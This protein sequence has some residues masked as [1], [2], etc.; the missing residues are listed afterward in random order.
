MATNVTLNG[1]TYSI[2]AVGDS[3]WGPSLSSFLIAVPTG[4]L[5]KAGG[6]FALTAGVD[7]GASFGL[8]SISY[9]G[10]STP[11]TAGLFRLGNAQAVSWR[12]QANSGNLDLIVNSSNVLTFNST[13]VLISAATGIQ[14]FLTTPS[15]ANLL[16]AVTD[17][18]GSGSLVFNTSPSFVTPAL[19]T[20]TSGTLTNCSGLPVSGISGLGT[21]VAT[22][23]AT[24]S[25]ANLRSA[26]T[27]ETGTGSLVFATSPTLVT[28]A[29]GTPTSGTLTNC[30]GLPVSTGIA[31]LATGV[32]T[33]LA[34][35][36]S[37]NLLAA[38]TDETGTGS[39]VFATSPALVTPNLGTPS[40]ATLT[41]ATGLPL[42]TGVTGTLPTGNGGTGLSSIGT[43]LQALRVNSAGTALEYFTITGTGDVVGPA[44]ATADHVA[45]F[46]GTTGKLIKGA[47]FTGADV[48]RLSTTQTFTGDKTFSGALTIPSSITIA[49]N[50][51]ERSGAHNLTLTTTGATNITLPTSGTLATT[52]NKL[53]AFAATTS[54]ELAGVISDETGSGA[55]VFGTSPTLG[56]TPTFPATVNYTSAGSIVKSGVGALTL[57]N[58]SAATLSFAGTGTVTAP[59]GS[60]TL[61]GLSLSNVFTVAQTISA[62]TNQ[63]VL[64][65]T[66]TTTITSPAP[67]ASRTYTIPDAGAAA[68]FVM[69]ESN[70]NIGGIK[71][72]AAATTWSGGSA[73]NLSIWAASNTLN[74][75]GGTAGTDIVNTSGAVIADFADTGAVTLGPSA[76]GV[77]HDVWLGSSGSTA[78]R[79]LNLNSAGALGNLG[80]N[81]IR[82]LDGGNARLI[83]GV[84]KH[85]GITSGVGY[86]NLRN[87]D[88]VSRN[89]YVDT[90]GNLRYGTSTTDIGTANGTLIGGPSMGYETGTFT[91]TTRGTTVAGTGTYITQLGYY[92]R[93]GNVVWFSITVATSAHTG[94]GAVEITGLPF[95]S[96]NS[97]Q[98]YGLV[99]FIGKNL[100]K[101][102]NSYLIAYI[103]PNSV[104]IDLQTGDTAGTTAT[105]TDLAMDTVADYYCFGVYTTST[106][107]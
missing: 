101:P 66:N 77:S 48:G 82:V 15:S 103:N 67:A 38:V 59:T 97:S 10:R 25:S 8:A 47:G 6:S 63:L 54:A 32:A 73:A 88:S 71:T 80:A 64:G 75:R 55:L 2:P 58:A 21:G 104:T 90:T 107:G 43:A 22:F 52:S 102:A 106:T 49:A 74:I 81:V 98:R 7:F 39:L 69:T 36:S 44:S 57:S 14:T 20:P 94:T 56:G 62:T 30:T 96:V 50:T 42:T 3:G 93:V 76:G 5:T 27:D 31:G 1:V 72:F 89:F 91:P 95:S 84:Y 26:V 78:E 19:G 100:T 61:A 29:L 9:A 33:F 105:R 17:E 51:F 83:M 79:S 53:S 37:A 11:A 35:P 99:Q 12:N 85:S 86:L 23:L 46:D 28:P 16:A 92:T 45:L 13:P 87:T 18:T 65:T 4:V 41:N 40:A 34:T 68:S 24:P 70:Q 60:Y